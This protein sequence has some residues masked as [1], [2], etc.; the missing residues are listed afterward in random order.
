[1]DRS[2]NYHSDCGNPITKEH[3][4]Y[5]F[6]DKWILAQLQ[7]TRIYFTDHMKLEKKDQSVDDS[8]LLRRTKYSQEQIQR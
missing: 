4:W 8:F 5:E 2:R 3:I 6:T 1:M 7:I